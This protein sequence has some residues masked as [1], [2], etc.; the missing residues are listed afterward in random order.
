MAQSKSKPSRIWSTLCQ[1]GPHDMVSSETRPAMLGEFDRRRSNLAE[2]GQGW[3]VAQM[4]TELDQNREFAPRSFRNELNNE[5]CTQTRRHAVA[6]SRSMF[7]V[8][9]GSWPRTGRS[10][11]TWV[12]SVDT[13]SRSPMVVVPRPMNACNPG[14]ILRVLCVG[15]ESECLSRDRRNGEYALTFISRP[16]QH[17]PRV[18][19][20]RCLGFGIWG[21][22]P[23]AA[24]GDTSSRKQ[25]GA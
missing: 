10:R 18:A 5:T 6:G 2:F 14:S 9:N 13:L 16:P 7:K 17:S 25:L 24:L 19:S 3:I 15:V 21:S 23:R 22:D 8:R 1:P 12:N 4:R 11:R 20:G